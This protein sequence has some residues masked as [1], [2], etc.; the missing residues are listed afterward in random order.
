MK[1]YTAEVRFD[2]GPITQ[3]FQVQA[4]SLV[5]AFVKAGY[6]VR[7]RWPSDVEY[8]GL[9]LCVPRSRVHDDTEA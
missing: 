6:E 8:V 7:R 4:E 9:E 1:T 2:T 3:V 5:E